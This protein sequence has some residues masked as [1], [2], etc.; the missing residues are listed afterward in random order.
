MT[1]NSPFRV[2]R[3]AHLVDDNYV[4]KYSK[5]VEFMK[6][7]PDDDP[8]SF[9]QQANIHCAYCA[10]AYDVSLYDERRT[11]GIIHQQW[12]T[13]ITMAMKK[14]QQ[15]KHGYRAILESCIYKWF[16]MPKLQ[17]FSSAAR[18]GPAMS[19]IQVQARSRTCLMNRFMYGVVILGSRMVKTWEPFTL[20]GRPYVLRSSLENIDR[21]WN[22]WKMIGN[23]NRKD[24]DNQD[25][26]NSSF[27]LYD[28][29]ANLLRAKVGDCLDTRS[30]GYVYQD[31]ELPWLKAKPTPARRPPIKGSSGIALAAEINDKKLVSNNDF[32]FVLDNFVRALFLSSLKGLGSAKL[33]FAA[34]YLKNHNSQNEC[35][36]NLHSLS[37]C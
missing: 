33:H 3:A 35:P 36:R 5:A 27:L 28:E 31:V 13:L 37:L 1:S 9:T 16:R 17:V 11:Q 2:L 24:Y 18:S 6:A 15:T 23:G 20:P 34:A 8:R 25:W 10:G 30:L 21:I 7:L 32:P 12:W 22:I 4:R 14:L 29:N 26:L 19:R